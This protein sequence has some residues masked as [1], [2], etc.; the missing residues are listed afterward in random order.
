MSEYL[1]NQKNNTFT[2]LSLLYNSFKCWSSL[3]SWAKQLLFKPY[4]LTYKTFSLQFMYMLFTSCNNLKWALKT[5][6][7]LFGAQ[8]LSKTTVS[9]HHSSKMRY[10]SY[11]NICNT[12]QLMSHKFYIFSRSLGKIYRR[13]IHGIS[14]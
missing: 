1:W 8:I 10:I 11:F 12:P 6:D 3:M 13:S 5:E 9:P 14:Y 4:Y 7:G 2:W